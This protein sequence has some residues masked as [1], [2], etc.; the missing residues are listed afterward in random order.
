MSF[1]VLK[2]INVQ[3]SMLSTNATADGL[4]SYNAAEKYA[5][6]DRVVHEFTIY[7]SLID[8][9]TGH[10]PAKSPD[11][12][13]VVGPINAMRAFDQSH[14]TQ[15]TGHESL[16]FEITPGRGCTAVALLNMTGVHTVRVTVTDP[17]YGER[18]DKTQIL[19]SGTLTA[20]WHSFFFSE[21]KLQKD[22][23]ALDLPPFP[24]AKIRIELIGS[25]TVGVGVVL[26]GRVHVIGIGARFG[27]RMGIRDFSRKTVNDWG[28]VV[29]QQRAH[30]KSRSF[31]VPIKNSRLDEINDLLTSLRATPVLWI[32]AEHWNS[33]SVYGWYSDFGILIA[34]ATESELSI[35]I[36]GLTA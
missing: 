33:P 21:R 7:Q 18:Y 24:T 29:L 2:P 30:S 31:S 17:T 9:N 8:D 6:S 20:S 32:A 35:D 3:P 14:S 15:T 4:P 11:E 13:V 16:V 10:V 23:R 1:R 5:A 36:E 27:A 34:Y 19:G 12:W 25:G 28:D 22:W 26:L